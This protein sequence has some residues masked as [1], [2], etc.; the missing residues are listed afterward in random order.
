M[1]GPIVAGV[2]TGDLVDQSLPTLTPGTTQDLQ[3]YFTDEGADTNSSF[4]YTF[5]ITGDFSGGDDAYRQLLSFGYSAR[6]GAIQTG[7]DD[8][9]TPWYRERLPEDRADHIDSHLKRVRP[10]DTRVPEMYVVITGVTDE[11]VSNRPFRRLDVEVFVVARLSDYADRAAVR[12]AHE[13]TLGWVVA[14]QVA[15]ALTDATVPTLTRG[16][17]IDVEFRFDDIGSGAYSAIRD[18]TAYPNVATWETDNGI[19]RFRDRPPSIAPVSDALLKVE[20][21][22]TSP[23]FEEFW[24]VVTGGQ[25]SAAARPQQRIVSLSLLVLGTTNEYATESDVRDALEVAS[26]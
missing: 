17:E 4:D 6:D 13:V 7:T 8:D 12:D 16:E 10:G 3:L 11:S 18:Y 1:T 9:G 26:V 25:E 23:G 24:A 20:P 19:P 22:H 15:D 21:D 14:D 5:D 2:E